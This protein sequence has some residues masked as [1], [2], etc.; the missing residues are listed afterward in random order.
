MSCA[1]SVP[2]LCVAAR[3]SKNFHMQITGPLASLGVVLAAPKLFALGPSSSPVCKA[4]QCDRLVLSAHL[5]HHMGPLET[6]I[7]HC[8]LLTKPMTGVTFA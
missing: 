2:A 6:T 7:N 5:N 1:S 4:C 8:I 3:I